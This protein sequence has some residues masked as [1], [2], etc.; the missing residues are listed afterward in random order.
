MGFWL[1]L[2]LGALAAVV[3]AET[4]SYLLT[5]K[6]IGEWL[7]SKKRTNNSLSNM[8]RA[9]VKEKDGHEVSFNCLDSYGNSLGSV[10]LS[11]NQGVSSSVKVGDVIDVD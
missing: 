10:K 6:T 11:S 7:S 2:L 9:I 1:D 8:T 3:I 4:V 5:D